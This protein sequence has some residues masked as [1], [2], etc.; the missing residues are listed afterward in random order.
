MAKEAGFDVHIQAME[1]AS[2]L[3]AGYAGRF[4]AYMIGWSGRSDPDGNM[5]QFLHTGGT[6]NY[7]HYSN[8]GVDSA[9]DDAR[10]TT[11]VAKRRAALCPG[12]E[13]GAGG[14]AADLFVESEKHRWNEKIGRGLRAG[15]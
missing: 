4:E 14:H 15:P 11:D 6:F 3:Q 8:P 10:L 9:L 5:W 13:P 1:F 7:G 2:S 12:L